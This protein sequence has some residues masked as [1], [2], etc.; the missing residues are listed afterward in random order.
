MIYVCLK[1]FCGF[2]RAFGFF[3]PQTGSAR[4]SFKFCK[5]A[6]SSLCICKS[7]EGLNLPHVV[8]L[9]DVCLS[10]SSSGD[11]NLVFLEDVCLSGSFSG[12]LNLAFLEDVCLSESSPGDLNPEDDLYAVDLLSDRSLAVGVTRCW[13]K[14]PSMHRASPT[15]SVAHTW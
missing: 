3:Y 13:A 4:L 1:L 5:S 9:E 11:L 2:G 8:F 6:W 12:D 7:S 15:A 14:R 10:G